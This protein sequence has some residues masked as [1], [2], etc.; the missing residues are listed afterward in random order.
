MRKTIIFLIF[1]LPL[2]QTT[3]ASPRKAECRSASP[4]RGRKWQQFLRTKCFLSDLLIL[5]LFKCTSKHCKI[6]HIWGV[7]T[8]VTY[9]TLETNQTCKRVLL[10]LYA[11]GNELSDMTSRIVLLESA[12]NQA[13]AATNVSSKFGRKTQ[14]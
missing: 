2:Q 9:E 7:L 13:S 14:V 5:S 3:V 1:L 4:A 6:S 10:L 11:F 12:L 8:V